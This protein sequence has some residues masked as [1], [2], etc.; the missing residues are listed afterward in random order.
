MSDTLMQFLK[1]NGAKNGM[2]F[3][4]PKTYDPAHGV[5]KVDL[6]MNHDFAG[7][8]YHLDADQMKSAEI[9]G[10]QIIDLAKEKNVDLK[11]FPEIQA[12]MGYDKNGGDLTAAELGAFMVGVAMQNQTAISQT[13]DLVSH[14]DAKFKV[15][16]KATDL[17]AALGA[18]VYGATKPENSA[19]SKSTL[20]AVVEGIKND[21]STPRMRC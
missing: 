17:A 4:D 15:P 6:N 2:F 7:G 12:A 21:P 16:D 9:V 19:F 20:D 1:E 3:D 14:L 18:E 5:D 10:Q 13:G 11:K 8:D